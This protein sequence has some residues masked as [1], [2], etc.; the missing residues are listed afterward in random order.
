VCN[1]K[2]NTTQSEA[3]KIVTLPT[4]NIGAKPDK[5]TKTFTISISIYLGYI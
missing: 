4:V 3:K 2:S 5:V 1:C